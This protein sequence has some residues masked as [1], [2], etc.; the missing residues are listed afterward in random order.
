MFLGFAHQGTP[1]WF[2]GIV[3]AVLIL[4]SIA[5]F[6]YSNVAR[7]DRHKKSVEKT[8][9]SLFWKRTQTHRFTYFKEVGISTA[10]GGGYATVRIKYFVQLLG[11]RNLSIPGFSDGYDEAVIK[12]KNIAQL[13]N[14]PLDENPKIGFFGKRL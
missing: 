7:L 6:T 1:Q 9:Q 8:T 12:A 14:L 3:G 4:I 5:S 10:S 11:F 13:L 2:L